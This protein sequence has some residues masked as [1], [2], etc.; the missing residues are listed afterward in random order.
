MQTYLYFSVF[1]LFYLFS[2]FICEHNSSIFFV[3]EKMEIKISVLSSPN[4]Y[5]LCQLSFMQQAHVTLHKI[6]MKY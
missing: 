1:F 4:G 5:I 6:E 3:K 2:K